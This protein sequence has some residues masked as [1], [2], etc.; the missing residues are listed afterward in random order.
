MF[1]SPEELEALDPAEAVLVS[2]AH[3]AQLALDTCARVDLTG[4]NSDVIREALLS[5]ERARVSLDA[6]AGHAL[7]EFD[8]HNMRGNRVGLTTTRWLARNTGV[9]SGVAR[10]RL[11]V[12]R[13]LRDSLPEVGDAL[14][15][16]R[17][18]WDHARVFAD[19][20]NDR[21]AELFRPLVDDLLDAAEHTVFGRWR[22]ET[23]A[24][25]SLLDADGGHD[26][27]DDLARNVLRLS[28]SDDLSLLRA[29]L[30]TENA[31]TVSQT[32]NTVA[33]ELFIAWARDCAAHPELTMPT[34]PTL[35]AQALV[36][37][38]RRAQA[39]AVG[40]SRPPRVEVTLVMHQDHPE[41]VVDPCG[42][43]FP[44]RTL[45]VFLC[46]PTIHAALV[47]SL[48]L[49]VDIKRASRVPTPAQRRALAIR[50]GGCT[51]PGC[52]ARIAWADAHHVRHWTRDTGPS[53]LDNLAL[54]CRRHHRLAHRDG[55][56]VTLEPD[57]WTLWT[58]PTHRRFWG[59]QHHRTRTGPEP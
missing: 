35:L 8:D 12:A 57:G 9:P 49:P 5:L 7:V 59:Q 36:E 16:G 27:A 21:N 11:A 53:D 4:A 10:Q 43:P 44:T 20:V 6:A 18:G 29:E 41:L 2:C 22:K 40:D 1:D 38:C 17:I 39:V 24:L 42:S 28:E 32:L 54:L 15:E 25:A 52:E 19:A 46:H 3:A 50:D 13:T 55:W 45:P 48:G 58:T 33:D 30:T 14:V 37:T 56:N 31:L 26:P 47:D 34:R 23:Q 51:F